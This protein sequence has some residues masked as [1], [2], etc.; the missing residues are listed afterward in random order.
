MSRSYSAWLHPINQDSG[1]C[2]PSTAP[3]ANL[4]GVGIRSSRGSIFIDGQIRDRLDLHHND[5][6]TARG[7]GIELKFTIPMLSSNQ[8]SVAVNDA[9]NFQ[10]RYCLM[11]SHYTDTVKMLVTKL[12]VHYLHQLTQHVY[13]IFDFSL[14]QLARVGL[15]ASWWN[16]P[17]EYC[18]HT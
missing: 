1:F 18:M 4:M 8:S 14:G 2:G 15:F 17:T 6:L 3:C 9:R 11:L 16:G 13:Y 5:H 10:H 12:T 7:L